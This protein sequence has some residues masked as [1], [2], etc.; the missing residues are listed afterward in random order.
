MFVA[1]IRHYLGA[2]LLELNGADAI[3]FTGGIGENSARF[4]RASAATWAGS[5]S[6]S[7]LR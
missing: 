1:S 4:A 5:A 7:T 6:S 2:Y 3:V